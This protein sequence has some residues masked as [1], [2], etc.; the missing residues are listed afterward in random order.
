MLTCTPIYI[1][2]Y[3]CIYIYVCIYIYISLYISIY[4]SI[5]IYIY[6]YIYIDRYIYIYRYIQIY[7]LFESALRYPNVGHQTN[8]WMEYTFLFIVSQKEMYES[9]N[10]PDLTGI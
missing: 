10:N 4:L 7:I 6:I 8:Y 9:R 3:I 5:Y 2:L 1:S